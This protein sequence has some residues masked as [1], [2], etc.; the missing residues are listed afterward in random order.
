M[1]EKIKN[2]GIKRIIGLTN[3]KIKYENNKLYINDELII[4]DF[5]FP[6]TGDFEVTTK[7]EG[8]AEGTEKEPFL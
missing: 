2:F 8:D 7:K 6:D 4:S 5:D 3:E 1:K